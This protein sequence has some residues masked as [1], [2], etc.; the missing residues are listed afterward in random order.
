VAAGLVGVPSAVVDGGRVVACSPAAR[1]A[2]VRAGQRRR[3]AEAAC[4][5]VALVPA[6]PARE[7]RRFLPVVEV[8]ERVAERV[9][10]TRPGTC[11]LPARGPARSAGGEEALAAALVVAVDEVL[12]PLHAPPCRVGIADTPFAALLAA[13]EGVLVP[14]GAT[15]D[16]LA[17]KRIEAIG[18]PQLAGVLRRLGIL[19]LGDLAA[20]PEAA[21][22]ARFG[23]PGR[24]ARRCARGEAER[25]L[26]LA[27]SAE[28][29]AVGRELEPPLEQAETVGF[30][31]SALAEELLAS[32]RS[33]GLA[34]TAVTVEL[35]PERGGADRRCWRASLGF[36]ARALVERVRWQ[37]EGW[38]AS[39]T[40][41]SGVA[42]VRMVVD[43]AERLSG[44]QLGLWGDDEKGER[45]VA[46]GLARLQG[47]FG[48]EAV[49]LPVLRGGRGP[50]EQVVLR[51]WEWGQ[52]FP[53]EEVDGAPWPGRL[54]AP[55]PTVL[56]APPLPAALVD[57]RGD[58]VE[59]G[60][61]GELSAAPRR[62]GVGGS[63]ATSEVVAWSP[64]WPLDERWWGPQG[65]RRARLQVLLADG[66]AH[67]LVRERRRWWA[68]GS[69]D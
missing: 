10:V 31:A 27:R 23:E 25:P 50:A 66:S 26:R 63:E 9:E 34:A 55:S 3:Q 24:R 21:V 68:E 2:G 36:D 40:P 20:L 30:V 11:C 35:L 18:D 56:Y 59:I 29:V 43:V 14:P 46:D 53:F 58:D 65:R 62:A 15:P 47:L 22:L 69:Y 4:P 1:A 19:R 7:L 33:R 67:L 5:G 12:A 28:R 57:A 42:A 16:F 38:A 41:R 52:A 6:D 17:G 51:T 37:L 32:L 54:P 49:R 64:P 39:G 8:L 60:V 48:H 45:R 44:R 61:R 13:S